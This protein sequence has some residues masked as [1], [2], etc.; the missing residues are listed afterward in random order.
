MPLLSGLPVTVLFYRLLSG[1]Q[2]TGSLPEEIGYLENLERIQ[3]DQN[4]ISGQLPKSF[5]NLK[6]AKHLHLNNNSL[7]GQIPPELSR[8]P[9]LVHLLLDNNNLSGY[10]PPDFSLLP[11]MLILYAIFLNH[12]CHVSSLLLLIC[13]S[14]TPNLKLLCL[15]IIF[16][17]WGYLI[18]LKQVAH[19]DIKS[20]HSQ[21]MHSLEFARGIKGGRCNHK[22]SLDESI[23]LCCKLLMGEITEI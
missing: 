17:C 12:I 5:S 21:R 19:L 11:N 9:S 1:N 14:V 6:A 13:V 2:F 16:I 3:I 23:Y 22:R 8:V 10:L 4:Q 20:R 7:S 18:L 15:H